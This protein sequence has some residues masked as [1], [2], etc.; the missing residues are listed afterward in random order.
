MRESLVSIV[1][2]VLAVGVA[3]AEDDGS[4]FCVNIY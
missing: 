1:I 2:S 4:L 3:E